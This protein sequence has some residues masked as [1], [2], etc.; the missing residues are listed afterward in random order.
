MDASLILFFVDPLLDWNPNSCGDDGLTLNLTTFFFFS[1]NVVQR[2]IRT[3][4]DL[5]S[6]PRLGGVKIN[7]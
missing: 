1:E 4:L 6:M 7:V 2:K 5:L 3:H